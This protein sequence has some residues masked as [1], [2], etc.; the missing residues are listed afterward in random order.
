[1]GHAPLRDQAEGRLGVR[2]LGIVDESGG[3]V[4]GP[5]RCPAKPPTFSGI[6]AL[7]T[8][9][10]TGCT[11]VQRVPIRGDVVIRP[12]RVG[13]IAPPWLTVPPQSYG[14]TETVVD[15]LARGLQRLGHDVRLF[16]VA[17]STCPVPTSWLHV[18]PPDL[19]GT[20][21]E[22]AA[23]VL[24]AYAELVGQVDVIHDH[25][26]LG[27]LLGAIA[28]PE[29]PPVV[30]THHGVCTAGNRTVLA[31]T[32]RHAAVVAISH[33]QARRADPIPVDAVIHHGVDLDVYTPGN[34]D[35]GYLLFVGRMSPDKGL[36]RA[37]R[38]AR[39]A[40]K[41]LVVLV[42]MREPVEQQYFEQVVRP[43]LGDDVLVE[44]E[45]PLAYRL[46]L[47][48]GAS[49]L[50]NPISWPEPFGLV[51]AE[52]LATA[53]PVIAFPNGAAV[54]IVDHGRTG[55]LCADEDAMVE[56]VARLGDLDRAA[57]REAAREHFS[58]ERMAA[59]YVAFYQ[60]LVVDRRHSRRV[61]AVA[62]RNHHGA[63]LRTTAAR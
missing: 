12:M 33:D 9:G 11:R 24:A 51:M 41:P 58:L 25:T 30:V 15:N 27:P 48:R 6:G 22:E 23:H 55:F 34:G 57:C 50:L 53:T 19:I 43:L 2:F 18:A 32:A 8:G 16:T 14:G 54:E 13:L 37:I 3:W 20:S 28:H 61:V 36:D 44:F 45:P 42:K 1:M 47:Q 7:R 21:L 29:R 35:G 52:A 4:E 49:A 5:F 46:E 62:A 38:V 39:R 56:A 59:Q 17:G 31:E 10:Q 40:R 63:S 26:L 60:G